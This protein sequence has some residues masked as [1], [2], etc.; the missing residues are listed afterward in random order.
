MFSS[1]DFGVVRRLADLIVVLRRGEIVEQGMTADVFGRPAA[2]Y[3]RG[4]VAANQAL[5][6]RFRGMTG[7]TEAAF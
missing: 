6:E 5:G 4:L 3:T 7:R 1:H 2:A